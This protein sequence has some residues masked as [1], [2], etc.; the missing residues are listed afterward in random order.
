MRNFYVLMVLTLLPMV[1]SA[2]EVRVR[3]AQWAQPMLGTD[4]DNF[5]QLDAGVYRS[6]QPDDEEMRMLASMGIRTILNL[7][8]Y[9]SDDDEAKNSGIAL[10]RIP[11]AAGEVNDEF[12]IRALRAIHRA[13]KPILIHCWHG[14][15]R[16]GVVSAMYRMVFQNWPR[17]QAIDEFINGGFGY[18]AR[19]YPNIEQ[20]LKTVD[21]TDIRR[22]VMVGGPLS[23]ANH[24]L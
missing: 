2:G 3:P 18:H 15:D 20:Y 24:R 5:Y 22:Q 14:S 7:R 13:D 19:F 16:T 1:L 6:K 21:V 12:V 23:S 8:E 10:I 9:H 4:L 11:V 17:E